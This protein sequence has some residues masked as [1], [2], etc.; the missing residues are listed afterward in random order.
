MLK[1]H[2]SAMLKLSFIDLLINCICALRANNSELVRVEFMSS[3]DL[4]ILLYA[5]ES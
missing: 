3:C 4:P 2:C 5:T 1:F